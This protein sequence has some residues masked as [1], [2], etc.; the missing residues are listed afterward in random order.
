MH[1]HKVIADVHVCVLSFV[2]Q[3]IKFFVQCGTTTVNCWVYLSKSSF[4]SNVVQ[5]T[6]LGW[7]FFDDVKQHSA[8][9]NCAFHQ[10]S[11]HAVHLLDV[12]PSVLQL[13]NFV[14]RQLNQVVGCHTSE[15]KL[16]SVVGVRVVGTA[17][18]LHHFLGVGSKLQRACALRQLFGCNGFGHLVLGNRN[19][20]FNFRVGACV[21][22]CCLT[23][24]TGLDLLR[25]TIFRA[26]ALG[27]GL[28]CFLKEAHALGLLGRHQ[29]ICGND[30]VGQ[31]V[32]SVIAHLEEVTDRSHKL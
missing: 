4:K 14:L 21:R 6:H 26:F 11:S 5:R 24:S 31:S 15:H 27:Q 8:W 7:V 29:F 10:T 18:G 23:Q 16:F 19:V 12:A 32:G 1:I 3:R 25:H 13:R 2:R 9:V 17:S 20:F 30:Q 28:V 22:P